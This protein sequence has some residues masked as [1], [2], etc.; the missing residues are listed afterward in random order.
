MATVRVSPVTRIEGHLEIEIDV[1][2]AGG[3]QQVLDARVAGTMF[4][5]FEILLQGRDPRDAVH[6]TQRICGVCPVSHA[7]ASALALDQACQSPPPENGRIVRNLV[8]AANFVQSHVLHFYHLAALDWIDPSGVLFKPPWRPAY[9]AADLARGGLARRIASGYLKALEIR[10]KTHQMGALFGGRLPCPA[11]FMAGGVTE[12]VTSQKAADFGALLAEVK[13]FVE[14]VHLPDVAALAGAFPAYGGIG[15]GPGNLLAFG[16]F[17][18]KGGPLLLPAGRWTGGQAAA[19]DPARIAEY[20]QHSWYVPAAGGLHPAAGVTQ[21]DLAKAGAYSWIKAPRYDG[22]PYELGPLARMWVAGRYRRG[23][24]VLDRLAARAEE[25]R[26]LVDAMGRWLGELQPGQP[27]IQPPAAIPL[28]AAG[29]GL[30]EAPRGALGH[31]LEVSGRTVARYQVVTP[32]A[33]NASPRDD[34]A[35][36]GPLEQALIGTPIA[37]PGAPVEALRVVHSFDPCLACSVHAL[38]ARRP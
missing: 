29:V 34:Q 13:A 24:S 37:D 10:R 35:V 15:G 19:F 11:T 26:V 12:A 32:T 2:A 1:G 20:V 16:V 28:A 30:T 38:Q 9:P 23:I 36:R 3:V 4:R 33:W 8:L 31:W 14:N 22:K 25:C 21:P 17:P 7:M 27:S 18:E 5:G 6:L